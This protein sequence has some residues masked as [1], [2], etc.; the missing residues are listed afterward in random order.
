MFFLDFNPLS[1][2]SF[3]NIFSQSVVCLLILLTVSFAIKRFLS[4][5]QYVVFVQKPEDTGKNMKS[6]NVPPSRHKGSDTSGYAPTS[7]NAQHTFS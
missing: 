6:P 4:Q 7:L 2:I 1:D 5:E 3:A